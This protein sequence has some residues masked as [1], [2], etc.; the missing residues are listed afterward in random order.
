M[1]NHNAD[2]KMSGIPMPIV[3]LNR[4][5]LCFGILIAIAT[6]QFWITTILFMILLPAVFFGKKYSLIYRT[7]MI[8]LKKNIQNAD[9]EDAS[10][11][12]FNNG[13]A[14]LLLGMSQIAFLLN[15]KPARL[16][17]FRN[18]DACLRHSIGR[19]LCGLFSLLSVLNSRSTIL[20]LQLAILQFPS[21]RLAKRSANLFIYI[22]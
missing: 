9:F 10:L 6:Q 2:Q 12:R 22:D 7:G 3:T 8:L 15:L 4:S 1:S 21:L 11:Q 16:D 19:I 5:I 14:T 20:P 17:F 18:G 13:I